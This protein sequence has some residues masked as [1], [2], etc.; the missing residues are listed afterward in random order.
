M[1]G[2]FTTAGRTSLVLLLSLSLGLLL[3]PA[4]AFATNGQKSESLEDAESRTQRLQDEVD[5]LAWEALD[6]A[7]DE[8]TASIADGEL[9]SAIDAVHSGME[10][11]PMPSAAMALSAGSASSAAVQADYVLSEGVMHTVSWSGGINSADLRFD[12]DSPGFV[13]ISVMASGIDSCLMGIKNSSGE[14]LHAWAPESGTLYG[15]FT[16][17]A[18]TYYVNFLADGYSSFSSVGVR[19]DYDSLDIDGIVYEI[20]GSVPEEGQPV[21]EVATAVPVGAFFAGTFYTQPA[22]VDVDYYSFT[23]ETPGEYEIALIANYDM[24]FGLTDDYGNVLESARASASGSEASTTRLDV[25]TLSPGTYNVVVTSESA[26]ALGSSYTGVVIRNEGSDQPGGADQPDNPGDVDQPG[27]P[28]DPGG[29]D[30]DQPGGFTNPFTDVFEGST[31]HYA[32]I[33]WLAESGVTTGFENLDGTFRFEPYS[34]VKRCDMAA[35]LY[36]LAGSPSYEPTAADRAR[37]SDVDGSTPH[38]DEVLWLAS[39]GISK[40]WDNGDGTAS[41]RPYEDIARVDMTAFLHRLA[42][43]M[44]APDPAGAAKSFSDVPSSMPHA[45]DV[46][47]LSSAGI[48]TGFPDGSFKPYDSIKRCDMAA[49]L[50]RLDGL[51][52]GYEVA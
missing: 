23:V 13:Y 10:E 38:C 5:T 30:P 14:M 15:G 12:L 36:R 4:S 29:V 32:H 43:W 51:V 7:I 6:S 39:T 17:Q 28:D 45:S 49:M 44:G 26:D 31:D 8:S 16:L 47:W 3:A 50:H 27:D 46:A 9:D 11:A 24:L 42:G 18:G 48:T 2:V 41:F 40:G 21:S 25:G 35:F 52:E 19:F 34:T 22:L 1:K 33:M 37:F 20:E